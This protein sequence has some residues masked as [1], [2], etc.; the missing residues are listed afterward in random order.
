MTVTPSETEPTLSNGHIALTLTQADDAFTGYRLS[1]VDGE[2]FE[3]LGE[4]SFGRLIIQTQD[5]SRIEAP[6]RFTEFTQDETK[7]TFEGSWVD[8][9]DIAWSLRHE[10]TFTGDERQLAIYAEA[11]PSAGGKV[12]HF[13][14]VWLRAG[15][16]SFGAAKSDAIF[17]GLE[18]L[19]DDEPSSGTAFSSETYASRVNPHPYKVTVPLM[20]LSHDG[21]AVGVMWDPNQ[22]YGS[23]WRHPAVAFSSPNRVE[24]QDNHLLGVF[25]PGVPR[26]VP[27]N[28]LEAERPIGAHPDDP[29]KI[30]TRIVA[31]RDATSID[32]IK[33]WVETFGLPVLAM[34]HTPSE[35][36]DFCV[37][38]YLDIAW[39]DERNGWHHTLRDPWGPRYEPRVIAQLWRYA[40][41]PEGDPDLRER[42]RD[43]VTRGLE[44]ARAKQ[45]PGT[46]IS[47][48]SPLPHLELALYYGLLDESLATTAE[49]MA[50]LMG[51]QHE[52]GSWVWTP[53]LIQVPA[54]DT[55]ER[56]AV[57]G[58]EHEDSATGLTAERGLRLLRWAL[59]SG[60]ERAREAGMR[61]VAWCNA[62]RRP[63]GAQTWELHLHVPD[64]LAVPY[65]I[66]L[67]L[68]AW[69]L[70]G[71][72]AFLDRADDWAWTGL[73]FTWLWRAY[74]RPIMAYGTVPSFGVTFHDVQ[75]WFGVDVHWNGL[76]YADALY[77]LAEHR[78]G[79]TWR[80]VADGIVACGVQQQMPDGPWLGMYPDAFSPVKG[81]EEYTW[82]LNPNLIGLNTFE[83]AGIPLDVQTVV[84]PGPSGAVYVT[85]G[86]AVRDALATAEGVTFSLASDFA[87]STT[88]I[89]A[90]V[91]EPARV[92]A[93]ETPLDRADSLDD[94]EAGWSWLADRSLLLLKTPRVEDQLTV[95]TVSSS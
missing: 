13:P 92:V 36:V 15:E 31:L 9:D 56:R 71:D 45:D 89:V 52:N 27:E 77:R 26:Y 83:L 34:P 32:I 91:A 22:D 58:S 80:A 19:L 60:D 6:V 20:A 85:S 55:A 38:S 63:E 53:D 30:E 25:A 76:V 86:G 4:A 62:Q 35:N 79:I 24:A 54:F 51:K 70:T 87:P 46:H 17:P 28:H 2:S 29:V 61:A 73:P 59:V 11:R 5:G 41:W 12:L 74:Y 65:L 40:H 69:Q 1:V 67:N 68:C 78:H 95:I 84:A 3:T 72:E 18:Y 23:A 49:Q 21:Y 82:W 44:H 8:P 94:V 10:I 33:V 57:M 37:R 81:D 50:D 43:Q 14:G 16:G 75:S 39:D 48:R 47:Q 88:T 7:L 64:V 66:D 93:G 42:A 90:G